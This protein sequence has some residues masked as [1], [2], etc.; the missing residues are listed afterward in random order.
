M[1]AIIK[2]KDNSYINIAA[3]YIAT[4]DGFVKVWLGEDLVAMVHQD[5]VI[6]CH[7]SGKKE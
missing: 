1:R 6:S 3:D 7:L 5:E 2:F 4:Q